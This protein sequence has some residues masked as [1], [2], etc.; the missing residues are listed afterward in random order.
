M[1]NPLVHF[2]AGPRVAIAFIRFERERSYRRERTVGPRTV[3]RRLSAIRQW[4]AYLALQPEETGVT[5][6]PIPAGSA[7]RTGAGLISGR[8]A[9]LRYDQSL[10]Q[11]L[12]ATEIECFVHHLT[13][14]RY[15]DQA[16][17][18][19][20]KD[21]GLRI[22]EALQLRLGDVNWSRRILAVRATKN[23]R[24]RLVPVTVEAMVPLSN[25]V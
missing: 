6:N 11:A 22:N 1:I 7:I 17:V 18:W 21:G 12:S 9:L 25:Y 10:P 15:R 13:A 14:T 16:I 4:Y 2:R 5:R 23:K 19:L 24:E 8:P 3:V 20:L